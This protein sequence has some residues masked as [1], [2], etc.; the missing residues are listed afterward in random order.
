MLQSTLLVTALISLSCSPVIVKWSGAS[1]E[2]LGFWRLALAALIIGV[3]AKLKKTPL[4]LPINQIKWPLLSGLFF[5]LHLWTYMQAAHNTS[6]AHMVIIYATNPIF[7]VIG[8]RLIFK[9]HLQKIMLLAY[10]I[11]FLGIYLLMKERLDAKQ[12]LYGNMMAFISAAFHAF[13]FLLS[14]KSRQK[15]PNL[16]FSF[17]LYLST[18]LLFALSA[19]LFNTTLSLPEASHQWGVVLLILLPTFGGHFLMTHLMN[20]V[21]VSTLA[22]SKLIEPGLSTLIAF[23]VLKE[24]ITYNSLMAFGLTSLAVLIVL[25]P[26]YSLRPKLNPDV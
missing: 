9:E 5:F 3:W 15:T 1:P 12:S 25:A 22:F 19:L 18:A 20:K 4:A 2:A 14:K 8:A 7:A 26:Q 6:I 24:V 13:Y 17:I 21:P 16:P 23:W 11:A 10:P